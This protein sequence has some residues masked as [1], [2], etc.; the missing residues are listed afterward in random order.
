MKRIT[1]LIASALCLLSCNNEIDILEP[2][3]NSEEGRIRLEIP[4]ATVQTYSTANAYHCWIFRIWVLE[5]N[6]ETLVNDT[7]ID[8]AQILGNRTST[9]L[10]PQLP[11]K[12]I[13]GN[14]IVFIA[15]P[16]ENTFP[17]PN[18][19]SIQYSNIDTYFTGNVMPMY[20][21]IANW[22]DTYSCK[23]IRV[24]A[25]VQVQ[26]GENFSD[27]TGNFNL[28]NVTYYLM[29]APRHGRY[30]PQVPLQGIPTT[31]D[32]LLGPYFLLQKANATIIETDFS[33]PEYPSSNTTSDGVNVPDDVFA[34][35]R[36]HIMLYKRVAGVD[37][38]NYRLDF[39][40]PITKKF[41]D[42]KRNHNYIFTIHR[43]NS[44]GYAC[45]GSLNGNKGAHNYPGSN[46]EYT[47]EIRDG[48]SHVT[49]NG[50]YAIVS[51]VDTAYVEAPTTNATVCTARY[52]LPAEMTS[53]VGGAYATNSIT[54]TD[55][56]PSGSILLY[57]SSPSFLT[58]TNA[59][60]V[61]TTT[62]GFQSARIKMHLGNIIHYVALKKK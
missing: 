60:I 15:N 8:G 23:M 17:H 39:Y 27:V 54:L 13:A 38:T 58:A 47:V 4:D 46:I 22:P 2:E 33:F 34:V 53:L 11:F 36:L 12:P 52:Q 30:L 62:S 48:S 49:S 55:V 45:E 29:N 9:Q 42:V 50:Q 61:V 25:K 14:R 26:L 24:Y 40:D 21:E 37:T 5:F 10:L 20:G 56:T 19:A 59:P 57:Y 35:K 32:P 16:K 51:S 7:F 18:R 6:G 41:I 43:V 1:F 31:E 3:L 44:E 28:E